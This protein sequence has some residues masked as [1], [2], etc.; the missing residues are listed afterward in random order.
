[1][2]NTPSGLFGGVLIQLQPLNPVVHRYVP[3]PPSRPGH[4]PPPNARNAVAYT[5]SIRYGEKH[6]TNVISALWGK[7]T[8]S[9]SLFGERTVLDK[10]KLMAMGPIK[11]ERFIRRETEITLTTFVGHFYAGQRVDCV[12]ANRPYVRA[13]LKMAERQGF[14]P[15]V[16][17]PGQL[18]SRQPRSA[19]P[20]S[21]RILSCRRSGGSR[22]RTHGPLRVNGF[23][24]RRFRPL[25]HSS[26][27]C[28]RIGD[29]IHFLLPGQ[30]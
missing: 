8:Q 17:L 2:P 25:S 24:D 12:L 27:E 21:L 6:Q 29:F 15:W 11:Y 4:G 20:A 16:P 14:E 1:M 19:T 9:L 28:L 26:T 23:Q 18:L 10:N 5:R 13:T 3:C 30:P 7:C 22:I